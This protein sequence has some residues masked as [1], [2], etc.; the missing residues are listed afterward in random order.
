MERHG[1]LAATRETSC[2]TCHAQESFCAACHERQADGGASYHRPNYLLGHAAEAANAVTECATC[3]DPVAFCRTCHSEAG[4]Q[5]AGRL[6]PGY[7]DAE[8]L[9]LLRHPQAARQQ[10]E[11]CTSCHTQRDCLQCHSQLGAFQVSPHGPDF[12]AR[13]AYERNPLVCRACHLGDPFG[14]E[15]P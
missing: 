9:W 2:A 4:L 10:L 5:S 14:G 7:H 15:A 6:G 1:T 13:R 12:D 11:S 8:P 3:H